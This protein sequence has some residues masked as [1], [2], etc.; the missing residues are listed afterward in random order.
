MA[1]LTRAP[2][3]SGA[4]TELFDR[5]H[6]LHLHAGQPAVREVA[7]GIGRGVI[8]HTTVHSAF[9]GP[10]VP[11]WAH[12]ELIVEYLDGSPT[13]FRHLWKAARRSEECGSHL[14]QSGTLGKAL[15]GQTV[16]DIPGADSIGVVVEPV[17]D[18]R[19][20]PLAA[21]S[22]RSEQPQDLVREISQLRRAASDLLAAVGRWA[23]RAAQPLDSA[24]CLQ[25]FAVIA[26]HVGRVTAIA[27]ASDGS[28]LATTG[29]D[30]TVRLWEPRTGQATTVSILG[31]TGPVYGLSFSP[32]GRLLATAGSDGTIRLWN[33]D[34]GVPAGCPLTRHAR[35]MRDVTFSPDGRLLATAS[36]DGTIR[37]W[38][39]A[40]HS[41]VGDALVGH[42]RAVYTLAFSPDGRLLASAGADATARLWDPATGHSVGKPLTEHEGTVYG[43]AFSPVRD[44]LATGSYDGTVRLWDV[45]DFSPVGEP[46]AGHTRSVRDV[47]FSPDG[48]LLATAGGDNVARL[49]SSSLLDLQ[50]AELVQLRQALTTLA[51]QGAQ[52]AN[53][54][55][56]PLSP[57]MAR[58]HRCGV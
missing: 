42:A 36:S 52:A 41:P 27:F 7:T 13:E 51:G 55:P 22:S 3:P 57:A 1:G 38:N 2:T 20:E 18:V 15:E 9:R 4:V 25:P 21:E 56:S 48:R 35:S 6:E 31:H 37:L 11:R 44:L 28:Q 33:V 58:R 30:A 39:V 17:S 49:W 54:Y 5:L 8:S 16:G 40:T 24:S 47:A 50:R 14:P 53:Q 23:L 12:L 43:V 46:L 19:T 29:A 34:N 26:G 45:P 32:D 10:K